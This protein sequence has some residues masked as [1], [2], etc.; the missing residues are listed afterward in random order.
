MPPAAVALPPAPTASVLPRRSSIPA[1]EPGSRL[2]RALRESPPVP[3]AS[4]GRA[5]RQMLWMT[6]NVVSR[7]RNDANWYLACRVV[8]W[9]AFGITNAVIFF[10]SAVISYIGIDSWWGSA[11]IYARNGR[12][13]ARR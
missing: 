10:S 8:S 6:S 9:I 4:S 1:R 5:R 7:E 2:P 11:R 13:D 12:G 3:A